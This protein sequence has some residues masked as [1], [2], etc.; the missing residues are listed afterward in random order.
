M[1]RLWFKV[2]GG[3]ASK[4][5]DPC[6]LPE[7]SPASLWWRKGDS[8]NVVAAFDEWW[9]RAAAATRHYDAV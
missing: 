3:A 2:A 6:E 5:G 1:N 4:T 7:Q 8:R 9:A